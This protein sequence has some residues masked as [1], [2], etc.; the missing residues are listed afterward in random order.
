MDKNK[1]RFLHICLVFIFNFFFENTLHAQKITAPEF[2]HISYVAQNLLKHYPPSEYIII[3]VGR[4]PSAI[5]SY[6][7]ITNPGSAYHLPLSDFRPKPGELEETG[8]ISKL[9][10]HFDQFIPLS[11][12]QSGKKIVLL[13]YSSMGYSLVS[14][15]HYLEK[16]LHQKGLKSKIQLVAMATHERADFVMETF[17]RYN[18]KS[19]KIIIVLDGVS[20]TNPTEKFS[21][22][23]RHQGYDLYAPYTRFSPH[24]PTNEGNNILQKNSEH[25]RFKRE[26][27]RWIQKKNDPCAG[28]HISNAELAL[29]QLLKKLW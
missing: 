17:H 22:N 16:Y 28:G 12:L 25:K 14:V 15:D 23:L 10:S 24:L 8:M 1:I 20:N 18:I 11:H 4:S 13:D 7:E 5:I 27:N 9:F 29:A 21:F 26:L 3:G 6:L 19:G 2:E